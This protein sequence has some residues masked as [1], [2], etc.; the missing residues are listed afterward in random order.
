[1]LILIIFFIFYFFLYIN[2]AVSRNSCWIGNCICIWYIVHEAILHWPQLT[3]KENLPHIK[4][5]VVALLMSNLDSANNAE[6]FLNVKMFGLKTKYLLS[7]HLT[8]PTL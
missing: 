6:G 3:K 4:Y 7:K 5:I 8:L 1:M 2:I